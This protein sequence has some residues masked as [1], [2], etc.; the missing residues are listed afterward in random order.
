MDG[1]IRSFL[2]VEDL[3]SCSRSRVAMLREL[4]GTYTVPQ[5]L[6]AKPFALP[7]LKLR[8]ALGTEV[9]M[10]VKSH[11][12]GSETATTP[13]PTFLG[14]PGTVASPEALPRS[15]PKELFRRTAGNTY[16][17]YM[18]HPDELKQVHSTID[19][20]LRRHGVERNFTDSTIPV[21]VSA[22]Y[23]ERDENNSRRKDVTGKIASFIKDNELVLSSPRKYARYWYNTLF[24]DPFPNSA[25]KLEI[26]T[27]N[28]STGVTARHEFHDD[29]RVSMRLA[30]QPP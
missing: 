8:I 6:E 16:M 18:Y 5:L 13:L 30:A 28:E 11:L 21:L 23:T 24:G 3:I 9:M 19:R 4:C 22:Y 10:T 12:R 29:S 15:R 14:F 2:C 1:G 17:A 25:R 20:H 27:R 7:T 26:V